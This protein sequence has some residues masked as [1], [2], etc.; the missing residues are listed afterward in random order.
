MFFTRH[1]WSAF[2][3]HESVRKLLDSL[4]K[5]PMRNEWLYENPEGWRW[6]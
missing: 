6:P 5:V 2:F 1:R 3:L 4:G